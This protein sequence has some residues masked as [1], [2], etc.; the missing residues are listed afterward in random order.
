[1]IKFLPVFLFLG[2]QPDLDT[3]LC[4]TK[5]GLRYSLPPDSDTQGFWDCDSLQNAEFSFIETVESTTTIRN[6]CSKL[7]FKDVYIS[8]DA[9][10]LD[11]NGDEV[12]GQTYCDFNRS[13]VNNN[14]WRKSS[15]THELLHL[16]TGCGEWLPGNV[17]EPVGHKGW[18]LQGFWEVVE[19]V[20]EM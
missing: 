19:K 15:F 3:I 16:I 13:V 9:Y 11:L 10:W 6:V 7:E 2:C 8:K 1:M 20:R 12:S 17:D 14:E 4:K 18:E 5:C